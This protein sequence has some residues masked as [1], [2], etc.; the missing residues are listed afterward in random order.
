MEKKKK[1][2][3]TLLTAIDNYH[4]P[5][6]SIGF[7]RLLKLLKSFLEIDERSC[8]TSMSIYFFNCAIN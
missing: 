6:E 1:K 2:R 3:A 4:G 5:N 8:D 7:V